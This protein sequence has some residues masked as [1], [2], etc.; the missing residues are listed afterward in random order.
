MYL[1]PKSCEGAS[2]P[3][4]TSTR[5]LLSPSSLHL[6]GP[7]GSGGCCWHFFMVLLLAVHPGLQRSFISVTL[8]L[9]GPWD[10]GRDHFHDWMVRETQAQVSALDLLPASPLRPAPPHACGLFS[11]A[12]GVVSFPQPCYKCRGRGPS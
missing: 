11:V 6:G 7:E 12:F 2:T 5:I 10:G 4:H 3:R 8:G 1:Q 9:Q